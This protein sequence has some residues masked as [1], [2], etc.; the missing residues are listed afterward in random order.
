MT[1]RRDSFHTSLLEGDGSAGSD[2]IGPSIR[3]CTCMYVRTS[4][5]QVAVP[6]SAT[7]L[8]TVVACPDVDSSSRCQRGPTCAEGGH[9]LTWKYYYY[10][11]YRYEFIVVLLLPGKY[12][13]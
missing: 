4:S 12:L 7:T 6:T 9:L 2:A 13:Y 5:H 10:S 3:Y 8:G 1:A 11:T